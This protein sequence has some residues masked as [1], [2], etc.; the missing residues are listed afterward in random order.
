MAVPIIGL[1]GGIGTGKSTVAEMLAARGAHVIDADKIG[2]E[3]YR[4]GTDGFRQVAAAFGSEIVGADGAIDRRVL[5]ARVFADQ[6]QLARLNTI[7]HPL[8]WAEIL[9]Q[10]E[11]TRAAAPTQPVVV[12][13]AIMVEA[14]WS[15]LVDQVW[16]VTAETELA[17]A[18]VMAGRGL[19]RAEIERRMATQMSEAERRRHAT[20]VIENNGTRAELETRVEVAWRQY[21]G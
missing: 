13:A 20:V 21:V 3:V 5:G 7:V 8:I 17:I 18:R 1:T 10:V 15:A 9:R 12:E 2:H 14:G 4:P 6:Y 19:D 16:L 11:A